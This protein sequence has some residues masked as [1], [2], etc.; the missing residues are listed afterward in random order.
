MADT[1]GPVGGFSGGST[2]Q[3]SPGANNPRD[4]GQE[5]DPRQRLGTGR[6]R[7]GDRDRN[8]RRIFT[9]AELAAE[10]ARRD[11]LRLLAAQGTGATVLASSPSGVASGASI[12]GGIS[13]SPAPV[14]ADRGR[15]GGGGGGPLLDV[16]L[17]ITRPIFGR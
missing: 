8:R 15:G 2:A 11:L 1:M 17:R 4:I 13:S 7:A 5:S 6:N 16:A 10:A 9:P 3:N 14:A 12:F